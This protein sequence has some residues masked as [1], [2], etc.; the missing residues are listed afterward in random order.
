MVCSIA[1]CWR[2]VIRSLVARMFMNFLPTEAKWYGFDAPQC[3][4]I[5]P[6]NGLL[7]E[8]QREHALVPGVHNVPSR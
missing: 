1:P 4:Q 2:T 8:L 3:A 6:D 5:V 7:Q